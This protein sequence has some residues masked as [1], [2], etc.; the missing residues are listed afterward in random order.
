MQCRGERCE[1][2]YEYK[3]EKEEITMNTS[4][5]NRCSACSAEMDSTAS[6][7]QKCGEWRIDIKSDRNKSYFWSAI[8]V[9]IVIIFFYGMYNRWWPSKLPQSNESDTFITSLMKVRQFLKPFSWE[10]FFSSGYGLLITVVFI[11]SIVLCFKFYAS[12]SKKM[13]NWWWI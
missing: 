11:I 12:A 6:R 7:C 1:Q 5:I 2:L 3:F 9:V 4:S 10:T 8:S 13:G